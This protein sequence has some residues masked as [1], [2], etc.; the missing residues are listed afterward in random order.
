MQ[1]MNKIDAF[2]RI[3]SAIKTY[4]LQTGDYQDLVYNES[5]DAYLKQHLSTQDW[6][7]WQH[8]QGANSPAIRNFK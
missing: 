4:R 5:A 6:H 3:I 7:F 2:G 8:A 1:L